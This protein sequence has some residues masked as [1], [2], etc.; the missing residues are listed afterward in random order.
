MEQWACRAQYVPTDPRSNSWIRHALGIRRRADRLRCSIRPAPAQLPLRARW[1]RRRHWVR[2]RPR[3]TLIS[4]RSAAPAVDLIRRPGKDVAQR[5]GEHPGGRELKNGRIASCLRNGPIERLRGPI[6]SIDA[7]DDF[8][9]HGWFLKLGRDLLMFPIR[10]ESDELLGGRAGRDAQLAPAGFL[11]CSPV[12]VTTLW[13]AA[14]RRMATTRSVTTGPV[15]S[16]SPH[17]LVGR[18]DPCRSQMS[19]SQTV[20]FLRGTSRSSRI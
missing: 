11:G 20:N 17:G 2:L 9:G 6:G 4:R 3:E 10:R 12:H 14:L 18:L 7:N 13:L 5:H 1:T 19:P 16:V 8:A 15:M